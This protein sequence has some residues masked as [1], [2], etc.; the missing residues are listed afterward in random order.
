MDKIEAIS[1]RHSVREYLDT[2]LSPDVISQLE[3]A[4]AQ[5]NKEGNLH[6]QLNINEP[7]AF[8][9]ILIRYGV[10]TNVKNYIAIIAKKNPQAEI[11]AGYYGQSLVLLAQQ[12]GLNT[13][14]V[15]G[16]YS[17]RKAIAKLG[18]GE[19]LHTVITLGYGENQGKKRKTKP[20]EKLSLV[21][22]AE[23]LWFKPAME[24]VQLA[25]TAMN[26]QKFFFTYENGLVTPE[27]YKGFYTN[28]DFGIA[29]LHFEIGASAAGAKKQD[30][31]WA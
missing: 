31:H 10:F 12:L 23:P 27:I 7:K 18:L 16:T 3:A 9:S 14:W 8:S 21:K 30:W 2:P 26:Q 1:A 15:G 4:I 29:K 19:K 13:C 22:G 5:V 25:P 11:S 6:F 28:I 20:I 17:K 24:A